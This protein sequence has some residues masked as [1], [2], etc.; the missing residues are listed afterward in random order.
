MQPTRQ[1]ILNYLKKRGQVTVDELAEVLDLTTVTVRHHLDILRRE[2]MV[3][4][5]V[6][7]HRASPGRPQYA[8]TL[9]A[10]AASQFPNNYGELAAKII[11]EIKANTGSRAINVIFEGVADRITAEAPR[12]SPGELLTDRLSRAVEFLNRRG[13]TARWELTDEGYLFHTECCPYERLAP[14]HPELCQMDIALVGN[15][16]GVIPQRLSRVVEGAETCCYLIREA[17][18]AP[19]GNKTERHLSN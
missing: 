15:L 6:I 3:A 9:T 19:I 18:L 11:E 13:Y 10:K 12:P 14:D 16:L 1:L 8:Y 5:P 2:E 7:L 17:D 4:E